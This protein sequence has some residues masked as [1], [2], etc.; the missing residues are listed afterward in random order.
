MKSSILLV[1]LAIII[2]GIVIFQTKQ[3]SNY[4]Y[5][6]DSDCIGY[7]T[8]SPK[9]FKC[10]DG[11]KRKGNVYCGQ[12]GCIVSCCYK[13]CITHAVPNDKVKEFQCPNGQIK[14]KHNYCFPEYCPISCCTPY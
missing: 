10:P 9:S 4:S 8:K 12:G 2:I 13:N 6:G 14:S 7:P 3:N 11:M 1:L 5:L